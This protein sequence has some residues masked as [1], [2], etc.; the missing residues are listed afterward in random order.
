[1]SI[2]IPT[3]LKQADAELA[4]RFARVFDHH[5][6]SDWSEIL[7]LAT[8]SRRPR[9]RP[10]THKR[11]AVAA[12]AALAV[13]ATAV[14]TTPAF[15]MR[16]LIASFFEG[17]P[18]PQAVVEDFASLDR[19]APAQLAPRTAAGSARLA[20]VF[21]LSDGRTANLWIAP[22]ADGGY[23]SFITGYAEGCRQRSDL[24]V[25][26]ASSELSTGGLAIAGDIPAESNATTVSVSLSNGDT[27]SVPLVWVSAPINAGFYLYETPSALA[28]QGVRPTK[29]VAVDANGRTVSSND[30]PAAQ[31]P[32]QPLPGH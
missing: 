12:F 3:E 17:E 13:A 20:H 24:S 6:D 26:F 11:F 22:S 21:S 7:Q 5:D 27:E 30:I 10:R 31:F 1:M 25:S 19:G 32:G 23:C 8:S 28:Q 29:V 15:G 18:A 2:S 9:T 14:A 16:G 4:R